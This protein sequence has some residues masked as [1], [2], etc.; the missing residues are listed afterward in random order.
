MP[1]KLVR[2]KAALDQPVRHALEELEKS[3]SVGERL[4]GVLDVAIAATQA[5]HGT[6]QQYDTLHDC[7]TILA[8]RGF[9]DDVI[10][11]FQKVRRD[12]N[13]SCAAALTQRM[14]IVI[15]DITRSYLFSGTPELKLLQQAGTAAVH[16]TPVIASSGRLWGVITMHFRA[17]L[18]PDEYDPRPLDGLAVC[19]ADRLELLDKQREEEI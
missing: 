10:G 2:S 6:I 16:S 4:H 3:K 13:S 17:T 5:D 8:S 1:D 9:T 7:L 14:R 12:T 18:R 19:L 11:H 15:D